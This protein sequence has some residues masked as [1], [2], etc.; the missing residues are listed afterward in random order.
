MKKNNAFTLVE[1]LVATILFL[2][3]ITA[4]TGI[5]LSTI[6]ANARV[7][8]M[9]KVQNEVRYIIEIISKEIRLGTIYYNYYDV[10]KLG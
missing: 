7:N 4:C 10:K 9:Q 1:V 2:T 8:L 5:F 6:R 3:V